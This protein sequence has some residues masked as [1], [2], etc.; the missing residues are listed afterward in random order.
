MIFVDSNAFIAL[1]NIDHPLYLKAKKISTLLKKENHHLITNNIVI[2]EVFTIL[3]MRVHKVLALKFEKE[4]TERNIPI[5]FITEFYHQKAWDI[6]KKIKDKNVN[7]FDCTSFAVMEHLG[8][9]KAFS[10]DGDFP[11]YGFKLLRV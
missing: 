4:F 10:F 11:K 9:K 3:A 7:F 2:S 6:F 8:I 5:I 1:W